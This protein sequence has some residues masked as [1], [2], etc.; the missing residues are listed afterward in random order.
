[1]LIILISGAAFHFGHFFKLV[2]KGDVLCGKDNESLRDIMICL[3]SSK[4]NIT[5]LHSI[6]KATYAVV[7]ALAFWLF[8]NIFNHREREPVITDPFFRYKI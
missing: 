4:S 8:D 7:S 3:R 2:H 5:D 1:M 6:S